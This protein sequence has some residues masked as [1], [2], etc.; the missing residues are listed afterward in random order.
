MDTKQWHVLIVEDDL[1]SARVLSE[2]L[3]HYGIEQIYV[4]TDGD[5]CL[6]MVHEIAPTV[7]IM[8]LLMPEK[9][10][11]QT[12]MELQANGGTIAL[13]PV[14]AVTAYYSA[15]V[16]QDALVAG[17][18]AC[19]PKPLHLTSFMDTLNEIVG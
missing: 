2:I 6:D 16:A 5:E 13:V 7:I 4:A 1:D 19:F 3:T 14:V 18:D 17:F 11:W 9:D 8:D 10:G 15:K 12:L